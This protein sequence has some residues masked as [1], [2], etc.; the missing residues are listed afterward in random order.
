MRK[1]L[2]TYY[3]L[4]VLFF[5]A[6]VLITA[7]NT[8]YD[9]G[10]IF[11]NYNE[12]EG[13]VTFSKAISDDYFAGGNSISFS[14]KAD[15]LYLM[16]KDI[17]FDG[18][19]EGA[20]AAFGETIEINGLI[21]NNLHSA[22]NKLRITGFVA[23]TAFIAGQS[24]VIG[25]DAVMDGTV[26]SGSSTIHIIGH[27]NNGLIAGAGE[28]LIDG[29]VLGDV[30]V[31]TGKLIITERGSIDGDLTYGSNVEISENEKARIT[32]LVKYKIDEK[33][34]EKG[35][36]KF[37]I[38]VS[39][40]FF[41]SMGVIGLLLLL[42]PGVKSLFANEREPASYGKTLLWGLIPLFIYPVAVL[43]TIPLFPLSIALGLASFPLLGLVTLLGLTF[44]GQLLFKLFKWENK[45]IFL[46]F[47]F[48]FGI[49][50]IFALIP[51]VKI[52]FVLAVSAMGA[53]LLI[54]RLF[55]TEF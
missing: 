26:F 7:Q 35:F 22:A 40:V 1:I 53:G 47:L 36:S 19:S 51:Y 41:F 5:G 2:Y 3:I 46:Q 34:D 23:E 48:A 8:E 15:D 31:R 6:A 37:C 43:V 38:I 12:S 32:G 9:A 14:G 27:L 42:L 45:N 44:G 10:S 52:P 16:G 28:V 49:F 20:M 24:I 21:G 55:K 29:P 13:D 17:L 50:V 39:I 11:M 54:S 30:N 4:L 25:E 18:E 33:I